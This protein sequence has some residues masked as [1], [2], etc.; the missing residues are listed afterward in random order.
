MSI[1]EITP[2][3]YFGLRVNIKQNAHFI[4]D[5]QILYPAGSVLVLHDY[6]E[7]RQMF[8]ELQEKSLVLELII[9][10]PSR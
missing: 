10:S 5:S 3:A 1:P 7:R 2:K 4:T 9:V 8:I 6:Y